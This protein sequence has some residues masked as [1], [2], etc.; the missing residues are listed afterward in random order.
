[1][2]LRWLALASGSL[3]SPTS[4]VQE[5]LALNI[6]F[7]DVHEA[8]GIGERLL[9]PMPPLGDEPTPEVF[10]TVV[11]TTSVDDVGCAPKVPKVGPI[12]ELVEQTNE[13]GDFRPRQSK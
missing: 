9:E 1:M 7:C 5:V 8:L 12:K 2:P 13:G 10:E 6:G 3:P 4:S 11:R